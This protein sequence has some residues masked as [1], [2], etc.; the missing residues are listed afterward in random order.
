MKLPLLLLFFL[1]L[2]LFLFLLFFFFFDIFNEDSVASSF[3]AFSNLLE[4]S[5]KIQQK[6]QTKANLD[7]NL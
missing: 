1:L 7:L 5:N 2:L 4:E 3:S 6:D